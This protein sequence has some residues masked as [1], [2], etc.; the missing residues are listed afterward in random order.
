[1]ALCPDLVSVPWRLSFPQI[2]LLTQSPLLA[3]FR[4]TCPPRSVGRQLWALALRP[5]LRLMASP[6]ATLTLLSP[7]PIMA[8]SPPPIMVPSPP[9][10]MVPSPPLTDKLP[11]ATAPMEWPRLWSV[12]V[13][14]PLPLLPPSGAVPSRVT[15]RLSSP[16][17][18][19]R[20]TASSVT[21]FDWQPL[22]L[23]LV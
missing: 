10:I 7:T 16:S 17:P 15:R 23:S 3:L 14:M 9:P 18:G 5:F 6:T 4:L 20:E 2:L 11:K 21:I 19:R 22:V 8:P 13:P 1:M 12:T